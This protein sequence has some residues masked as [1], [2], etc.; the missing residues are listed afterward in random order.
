V[1]PTNATFTAAGGGGTASVTAPAGCA[2]LAISNDAWLSITGGSAGNGNGTVSYVAVAN[3]SSVSR[4]G[5]LLVANE[6]I[7]VVQAGSVGSGVD[8][9]IVRFRA[10]KRV[11][12]EHMHAVRL[13]LKI[14][15]NGS[16]DQPRSATVVGVQNGMEVYRQ[17]FAVFAASRQHVRYEL[18]SFL[19]AEAGDITWT[20]TITD[21]DLDADSATRTTRVTSREK[22]D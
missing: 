22:F 14:R 18:P 13:R 1:T 21:D 11:H 9:D 12:L 2:W 20:A 7:E 4:T 3:S 17:T 5:S 8:L 6:A 10:T 16:V 19:P 15:N